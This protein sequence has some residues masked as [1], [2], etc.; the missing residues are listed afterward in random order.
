M[1]I[2]VILLT[3]VGLAMDAFA[4]A[5]ILGS[6]MTESKIQRA[7]QIGVSFGFFQ[8]M[9][10]IIG[11]LLG[12]S[13]KQ[14]ITSFDHWIAFGLLAVIGLKM[15]HGSFHKENRAEEEALSHRR[16]LGLSVATSIDALAVGVT[17]AFLDYPVFIAATIIG[18]VTFVIATAG[19]F[20][21]QIA[22]SLWG[23]RAEFVGGV[24]LILIGIKILLEHLK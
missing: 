10:P 24:I 5:V 2:F 12:A 22:S 21:G 15:I 13:L 19:V 17:F 1:N 23:R 16:L 9:M 11:W 20:I 18:V 6:R 4:V 8:M 14:L 7:L 3:A